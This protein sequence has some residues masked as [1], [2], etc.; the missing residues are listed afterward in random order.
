MTLGEHLNELRVRLFRATVVIVL[1]FSALYTYR[2]PLKTYLHAQPQVVFE[3][4]RESVLKPRLVKRI[5][6]GEL[7]AAEQF[8]GGNYQLL[9]DGSVVGELKDERRYIQGFMAGGSDGAM[10]Y[11][12]KVCFWIA[13]VISAPVVLWELWGFIAAGLYKHERKAVYKL[14]PPSIVL[15]YLGL[16]FGFRT[17]VPNAIYFLQVDGLGLESPPVQRFLQLDHYWAFLRGLCIALGVVFQ[18]PVIQ[19]VLS[20]AG[21]VQPATYAKYRGH[22]AIAL[23]LFAGII[24]P[25]DVITQVLLAGPAIVLWEIGYWISRAAVAKDEGPDSTDVAPA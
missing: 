1:V 19:L 8:V 15:F 17:M 25:P 2:E 3:E 13:L 7:V 9:D 5:E 20:K 22:M 18:I 10:F 11:A 24:T 12:L 21:L 4:L 23:L 14:L 16:Y 6:A